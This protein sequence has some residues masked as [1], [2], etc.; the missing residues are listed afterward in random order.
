MGVMMTANPNIYGCGG[1]PAPPTANL[2]GFAFPTAVSGQTQ[3][4]INLWAYPSPRTVNTTNQAPTVGVAGAND[5]TTQLTGAGNVVTLTFNIGNL[6]ET[7][8]NYYRIRIDAWDSNGDQGT[9]WI[10]YYFQRLV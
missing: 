7:S 6:N 3:V 8:G 5:P 1:V 4:S 9:F 10:Y 2:G